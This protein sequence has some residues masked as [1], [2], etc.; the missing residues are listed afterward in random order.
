MKRKVKE[1]KRIARKN[2]A[3]N[4]GIFIR[5]YVLTSAIVALVELP[6]A[7][8][9]NDDTWSIPN[10]IYLIAQILINIIAIILVC[11]QY[12]LHL[13]LARTQAATPQDFAKPLRNQPDRYIV[14]NFILYGLSLL[15]LLPTFGG[16]A[17]VLFQD[18]IGWLM[19]A[20]ILNIIGLLLTM[21]VSLS[22]NLVFFVMLDNPSM[23]AV[24]AFKTILQLMKTHKKRY[25]YI[26]FSFLGMLLLAA[27]SF[28]IGMLWVEP[29][30][31][32][33]VTLFYLDIKDELD[34]V[35]TERRKMEDAPEPT[36]INHYV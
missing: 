10:I 18:T 15:S 26:Q 31:S 28:G 13:S 22:F 6:F 14:A 16:M 36:V 8:L 3:G 1:L 4:Y 5:A 24:E 35:L 34:T 20:L 25:L 21:Y 7:M 19:L 12:N 30:M 9:Q 17:I 27:L 11:G 2:L 23:K 33:T 29:Y 32:Q